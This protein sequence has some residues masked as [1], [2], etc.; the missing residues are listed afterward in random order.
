MTTPRRLSCF[1]SP[2]PGEAFTSWVARSAEFHQVPVAQMLE[3]LRVPASSSR[4]RNGVALDPVQQVLADPAA[5]VGPLIA[6]RRPQSR[7]RTSE[8]LCAPPNHHSAMRPR[9]TRVT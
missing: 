7:T 2:A 3:V 9:F 5:H 4:V 8:L 6:C 1:P